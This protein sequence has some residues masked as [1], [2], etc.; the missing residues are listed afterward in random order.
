MLLALS[1]SARGIQVTTI[2]GADHLRRVLGILWQTRTRVKESSFGLVVGW[3][4]R[5]PGQLVPRAQIN[6]RVT[7]LSV[8]E[9]PRVPEDFKSLP[10]II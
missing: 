9:S 4:P 6:S 8:P 1:A 10:I 2:H 7:V 5:L 3:L